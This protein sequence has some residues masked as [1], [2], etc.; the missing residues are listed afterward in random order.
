MSG[1]EGVA[2][3]VNL[4]LVS[5]H[6]FGIEGADSSP[7]AMDIADELHSKKHE[8]A[9]EF[10]DAIAIAKGDSAERPF[11]TLRAAHAL[12]RLI[13][14]GIATAPNVRQLMAELKAQR[15]QISEESPQVADIDAALS[16]LQTRLEQMET[17]RLSIDRGELGQMRERADAGAHAASH[18]ERDIERAVEEYQQAIAAAKGAD[19][20]DDR[21]AAIELALSKVQALQVL[22]GINHHDLGQAI[23]T[24]E[25]L[26]LAIP[27]GH[28]AIGRIEG[29]IAS[30]RE[31]MR[32]TLAEGLNELD[33]SAR[34]EYM[35]AVNDIMAATNDMDR[36]KA[37]MRALSAVD[38][39]HRYGIIGD[40]ELNTILG[41]LET[42]TSSI[43]RSNP[44]GDLIQ[45]RID[46][47]RAEPMEEDDEE[48]S[49]PT[50]PAP[51]RPGSLGEMQQF[52]RDRL[53]TIATAMHNKTEDWKKGLEVVKAFQRY[54]VLIG[55]YANEES[56]DY[57]DR[58]K[59]PELN[60]LHDKMEAS[61]ILKWNQRGWSKEEGK[62]Y[63]SLKTNLGLAVQIA[64]ASNKQDEIDASN[65]M[66]AYSTSAMFQMQVIKM[67]YDLQKFIIRAM[68]S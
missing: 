36:G 5:P 63:S 32:A 13:N 1:I 51:I 38:T 65:M 18:R 37:I 46:E 55:E 21:A 15:A 24:I 68:S 27:D 60:A 47:M 57:S 39:M 17:A 9:A 7:S 26:R 23:G 58:E 66:N 45:K 22:D 30:A 31:Q 20:A 56:F 34:E 19:N 14:S 29:E 53:S 44:I 33:N 52:F 43:D 67:A 8:A 41:Q 11:Q 40:E 12:Q 48:G 28:A 64:M 50:A 59:F 25:Q 16:G 4:D 3:G 35:A 6:E 10:E 62:N 2:E 54:Q 49:T 61:G 42:Q